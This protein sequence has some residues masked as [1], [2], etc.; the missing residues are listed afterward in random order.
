MLPNLKTSFLNQYSQSFRRCDKPTLFDPES[1]CS[2]YLEN[3]SAVPHP[4]QHRHFRESCMDHSI[5][6]FYIY[7][8]SLRLKV[9][10]KLRF[11]AVKSLLEI[12]PGLPLYLCHIMLPELTRH[13]SISQ[14]DALWLDASEERESTEGECWEQHRRRRKRGND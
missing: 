3:G 1:D 5:I 8:D 11:K 12:I 13:Y 6:S 14:D 2:H 4:S 10:L 9:E 7:K